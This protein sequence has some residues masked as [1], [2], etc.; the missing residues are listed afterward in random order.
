M[1]GGDFSVTA[2]ASESVGDIGAY[3]WTSAQMVVDVQ[4]W[5]DNPATNFGWLVLGDESTSPTAKR[6]DTRESTSPPVLTIEY[7]TPTPTPTP[8][9]ITLRAQKK[10]IHG[11]N[12]VRLKWRGATSSNVDVY[13]NSVLIVTTPNDGLYDDSTGDTGQAQYVYRVCEA[14]TQTCSNDVTVIF[15]Q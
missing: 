10:K 15:S 2:S 12:S 14:G 5:L 1:L 7:A 13:R 9:P 6:F 11:I 8:G 4:S 3:V